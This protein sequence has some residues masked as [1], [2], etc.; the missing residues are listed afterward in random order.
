[1]RPS[2]VA[3]LFV[4]LLFLAP[5]ADAAD[6]ANEGWIGNWSCTIDVTFRGINVFTNKYNE[7]TAPET[8]TTKI[9]L[10][11]GK[12]EVELTHWHDPGRGWKYKIYEAA[13]N[14]SGTK[15]KVEYAG[16]PDKEGN[17]VRKRIIYTL[18]PEGL[19]FDEWTE[20]EVAT[21]LM[22]REK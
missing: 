12:P 1:M 13:F 4:S 20:F 7:I 14:A 3:L 6:A 8:F 18:T 10:F 11:D 9:D 15:L 17:P 5:T 21:C 19:T 2:L 22:R 16:I